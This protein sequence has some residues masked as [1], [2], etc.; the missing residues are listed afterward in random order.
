MRIHG[1]RDCNLQASWHQQVRYDDRFSYVTQV[2]RLSLAASSSPTALTNFLVDSKGELVPNLIMTL[3][4]Q[5]FI[6][7]TTFRMNSL[8][9]KLLPQNKHL[10]VL[11]Y[12][13]VGSCEE[14]WPDAIGLA[15]CTAGQF[16]RE[17]VWIKEH[18]QVLDLRTALRVFH[19][20]VRCPNRA[21]LVTFDDG[22]RE[23]LF[24]IR[25]CLK[26][27]E[28]RPVVFLSTDFIDTSRR[29]F[30]DR[31][32]AC[33]QLTEKMQLNL[34]EVKS[35]SWKLSTIKER[36][37]AAEVIT[38]FAK[39]LD[40][41]ER[42][43]L[44]AKLEFLLQVPSTE[45][46]PHPLVLSWDEARELQDTFDFGAHT[47]SHPVLSRISKARALRELRRSKS[48]VEKELGDPCLSMAIPFGRREDYSLEVL[49]MADE[50]Q[51]ELVFLLE[52][53][54]RPVERV[55]EAFVVDRIALSNRGGLATLALKV[56]WPSLF[57]PDWIAKLRSLT[58]G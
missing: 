39:G 1:S 46:A 17:M 32:A 41:E 31:I 51:Y 36:M 48:I 8:L 40:N 34:D 50:A 20:E 2:S 23:D 30:W 45:Y 18:C 27:L 56:T 54:L 10:L 11:T 57:V 14:L 19:Q 16:E 28:I 35:G 9:V 38:R 3:G 12:H 29:F 33:L 5:P 21:V 24:R 42:D 52:D 6:G 22:Y 43:G 13:R 53:A 55:G 25:P 47:E 44:I 15:E 49:R 58:F 4:L 26:H 7:K 37:R